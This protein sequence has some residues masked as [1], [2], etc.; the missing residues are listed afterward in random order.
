M[1]VAK[2][3]DLSRKKHLRKRLKKAL[4]LLLKLN[5]NEEN[6]LILLFRKGIKWLIQKSKAKIELILCILLKNRIFYF[7][8][9]ISSLKVFFTV[10]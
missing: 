7:K 6:F 10:V 8:F 5:V 2:L 9:K 3:K 4:T 1:K